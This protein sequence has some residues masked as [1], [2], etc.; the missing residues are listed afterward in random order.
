MNRHCLPPNNRLQQAIILQIR[1]F[2]FKR[3]HK[4]LYW[5]LF[6]IK[7]HAFRPAN[8]FKKVLCRCF[9]VN[10]ENF[11][12]IP[13]LKNISRRLLLDLQMSVSD[14]S[15]QW[16][17][18]VVRMCSV[19]KVFFE[20]SRNSLENTC[21]RVSFYERCGPQACNFIKKETPAQIFSCAGVS[22]LPEHLFLEHLWRLLLNDPDTDL[23]NHSRL[24]DV[25]E[26]VVW[27]W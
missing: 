26:N 3:S 9:P 13:F 12:R 22:F 2:I 6:L 19:K 17:E 14:L 4:R 21:A 27:I 10:T 11:S 24:L 8:L 1:D 5:S 7:L 16:W 15:N 23:D 20:I 25:E 18:A